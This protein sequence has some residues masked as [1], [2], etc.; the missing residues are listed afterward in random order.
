MMTNVDLRLVQPWLGHP[1]SI[2]LVATSPPHRSSCQ[3][4]SFSSTFSW[5]LFVQFCTN[6][7]IQMTYK[8]DVTILINSKTFLSPSQS[9]RLLL[10]CLASSYWWSVWS[11]CERRTGMSPILLAIFVFPRCSMWHPYQAILTQV[12][13]LDW[14]E[15]RESCKN[16]SSHLLLKLPPHPGIKCPRW[17]ENWKYY[18]KCI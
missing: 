4:S 17:T 1:F 5:E 16:D 18:C 7:A 6:S 14:D 3:W 8:N 11:S 2:C 10:R 15:H 12:K 13:R 9:W